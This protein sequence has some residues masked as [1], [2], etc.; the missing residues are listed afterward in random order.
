MAEAEEDIIIIEE[1][2]AAKS[3]DEAKNADLKN[4]ST[5]T[6]KKIIFIGIGVFVVILIIITLVLAL[7]SDKK[8]KKELSLDSIEER[9]TEESSKPLPLTE[10]DNMI[11]KANY[12]YTNGSKDKA[13]FLYEKIA[14]FSESIS[15]YNLGVAQLK[16]KQYTTALKSFQKAINNG[17]KRCV[18][19]I[20]AAVCSLHINDKTNFKYYIDLAYAYLPHEVNS[21]LYSY[22][23]TLVQYYKDN[24]LETLSALNN[25]TTDAY[26]NVQ[27]HIKARVNTLLENNYDAIENLENNYDKKDSFA[28]G[29]LYARIGDVD[30]AKQ[31]LSE[32]LQNNIEPV[33][34][35]LALGFIQL[36]SGQVT[37]GSTLIQNT[38]DMFGEEVYK[39]YPIKVT[40]KRELF[41]PK[42]SQKSYRE[43]MLSSKLIQYQKIFYFSP[44]KIFNPKKSLEGIKKGTTNIYLDSIDNAKI[45]LNKSASTSSVN[46]GIVQAIKLALQFKT[47]KA[48]KKLLSLVKIQPKHSIL[49]YNLA[50]TYAQMGDMTHAYQHFL[51]S[52][53]LDAKNYLSGLYAV[54]TAQLIKKDHKRLKADLK[55]YLTLEDTSEENDLL[56]TILYIADNNTI[57][58][59]DWLNNSYKQK[60]FYLAL[61]ALIAMEVKNEA[62]A[63]KATTALTTIYPQDIIPHMMYI[64]AHFNHLKE[65]EYAFSVINYLKKQKLSFNDLYY[66]PYITR[67]LYVRQNLNIGKLFFLRKQL[68]DVLESTTNYTQELNGA[69]ALACLYDKAFEESYVL[70]NHLIDDLKV[71]DA[72]TLFLGAVASTAA[73]HHANAIALLELSKMKNKTLK[74]SRYALGLLYLEDK[75]NIG[76]AIQ[77]KQVGDND[78]KSD[79]FNFEI[80][81]DKLYQRK[82]EKE[83]TL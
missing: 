5:Q 63:K 54:M 1:S 79:Y 43:E 20:N 24:Y 75:N 36:K 44:Y 34:S 56:K 30:L 45:Y 32:A 3:D 67:Y 77:L 11:A 40:L 52:Y 8:Q 48:N 65:N 73:G 83:A 47:R 33:K 49:H 82:I 9:L 72:Y 64:D 12:L 29:L 28:L 41:E 70:Y 25:P 37:A 35:A 6:K 31:H 19:A 38:T 46:K 53:H 26:P 39:P 59:I 62:V 7:S 42:E 68:R 50:L 81:T 16:N 55:E 74:E 18:S 51:S 13:L 15:H 58:A 61:E 10:L 69:L 23:Y 22:Y 76:A 71:R 57:S 21:P 60:P 66:G 27:K 2:D 14:E 78:F 80:D 4:D 17:E